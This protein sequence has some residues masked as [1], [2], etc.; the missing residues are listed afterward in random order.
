MAKKKSKDVEKKAALLAKKDAKSDKSARKRLVKEARALGQEPLEEGQQE[1][2][3][4]ALLEQ[5]KKQDST[6]LETTV[7]EPLGVGVFPPARANATLTK[8][9]GKKKK[10]SELYLFGGEYY[11]GVE[12]IVLDQLFKYD[13]SEWK[14]IICPTKPPPRCAH[15]CVY[16]NEALYIFGGELATADQYQHYKD[17]WKFDLGTL[18]WTELVSKKK[19]GPSARSGH[20]CVVWKHFMIVFGG[21]Y[22]AARD[23]PIWYNDVHVLDLRQ[24]QWM[25]LPAPSRL[26]TRPEPR[27]ACNAA[28]VQGDTVLV[29]GGFSKLLTKA[30]AKTLDDGTLPTSETVV[31][32]DAWALH[33]KPLLEGKSP[34]WER[35]M[36]SSTKQRGR[37]GTSCCEYKD[38]LLLVYGGVVDTERTHHKVD[39]VFYNDLFALDVERRKWFPIYA[40]APKTNNKKEDMNDS[41]EQQQQ[42]GDADDDKNKESSSDDDLTEDEGDMDAA[43]DGWDLEKLRSNMFAFIDGNGRLIYEKIE[44][45]DDDEQQKPDDDEEKEESKEEEEFKEEKEESKE[46][47]DKEEEEESKEEE[48]TKEEENEKG[49]TFDHGKKSR[50]KSKKTPKT[51]VPSQPIITSS[52]VM[53]VDPET[54][55]PQ[56]VERS[57]PLPRIKACT[58][59]NGGTLYVYGGLLEV[60]D[61]EVTL[62]DFWSF[63]LKRR[64]KWI[65]LYPGTM[66]RQ[67]WKGAIHDDDDSYIGSTADNDDDSEDDWSESDNE[68][69]AEKKKKSNSSLRQ[70]IAGWNEKYGLSDE[71]RTP[72][73]QEVLNEFYARTSEYWN[74]QAA[75]SIGSSNDNDVL[76]NKELKREGFALALK[77]YEELEPIME[78]LRELDLDQKKDKDE[79]KD[80][81][82]RKSDKKADSSSSKKK[83][84]KSRDE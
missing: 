58:S 78:R 74:Q 12:N 61:R 81:V 43:K 15:T 73:P 23:A 35:W 83:K 69:K 6:T 70:E 66:H 33:L 72:Q 37:S 13:F 8:T 76:S 2:H 84:K 22:E 80:K 25:D 51:A 49:K 16:Y 4:D 26:S 50:V 18:T 42:Q 62:D 3:L 60:G 59:V 9:E 36:N 45:D 44:E 29:H 11:N 1:S 47:E 75:I 14:R 19:L 77:R 67:V 21:F 30:K 24:E 41:E 63:D 46:E 32:T 20:A 5:Y 64:E 52:S 28:V 39:S 68:A 57:E 79:K 38:R 54:K 17:I 40:K 31:H 56:A 55:V 53:T 48:E 27:S 10:N 65:C 7:V 82:E 34:T 71:N